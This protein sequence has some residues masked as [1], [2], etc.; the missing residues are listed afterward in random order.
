MSTTRTLNP[1]PF[2]HLE[3]KRFEDLVRQ[4]AYN[5]RT[6]RSLEATGSSG[7]DEGFDVRGWEILP[8]SDPVDDDEPNVDDAATDRLWLFQ[9]K[10]EKA[11]GPTKLEGYFDEVPSDALDALHGLVFVASCKLSKK[12]RDALRDRCRIAGIAECHIWSVN[13]LEDMLFQPSNDNL[14]FAYFGVSLKIR[15]RTARSKIRSLLALKRKAYS[16]LGSETDYAQKPVLLRDP[17]D[18]RYPYLEE[19]T[20]RLH[21]DWRVVV[22]EGHHALGMRY[23][24]ARYFAYLADDGIDWDAAD[25]FNDLLHFGDDPWRGDDNWKTRSAIHQFWVNHVDEKNRATQKLEII[26]PYDAILDIDKVGDNFFQGPHVFVTFNEHSYP[27]NYAIAELTVPEIHK[28]DEDG[29][30]GVVSSRRDLQLEDPE[31]NRVQI[32]PEEYRRKWS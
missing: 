1:L 19:G 8:Y 23:R 2:E 26:I 14:L 21:H 32:F 27:S 11:I 20:D 17:E 15:Q 29:R 7:S 5:F 28:S 24:I 25:E 30:L 22:F 9:C 18:S 4:L 6:W 12:S 13:E 16:A 3:P 31:T 10:R